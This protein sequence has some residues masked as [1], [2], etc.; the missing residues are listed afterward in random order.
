MILWFYKFL[1]LKLQILRRTH[2]SLAAR[3]QWTKP[4]QIDGNG[5][6]RLSCDVFL[7]RKEKIMASNHQLKVINHA[8]DTKK[9]G[10]LR[11]SGLLAGATAVLVTVSAGVSHAQSGTPDP[12]FGTNGRVLTTF[13]GSGVDEATAVAVQ[14]DGK[15]VAA[16][17]TTA[18]NGDLNFAL[19][20]YN[21]NGTIDTTFG[22]N[23]MFPN[24]LLT[25]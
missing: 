4:L 3:A 23:A 12:T 19:V 16:G 15:I 8:N 21:P 1:I 13:G 6:I 17:S 22:V 20:R 2:V 10:H 24:I 7:Y 9:K 25:D 14:P 5:C 18:P 11:L